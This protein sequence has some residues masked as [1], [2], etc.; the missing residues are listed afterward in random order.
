MRHV[1]RNKEHSLCELSINKPTDN[2]LHYVTKAVNTGV[3]LFTSVQTLT[4]TVYTHTLT[5]KKRK[6][7][8]M[9]EPCLKIAHL[10]DWSKIIRQDT[11][12]SVVG[13]KKA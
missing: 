4:S 7:K 6:A 9:S 10:L 1:K 11:K 8:H 5:Y 13:G 2:N 3:C 12:P